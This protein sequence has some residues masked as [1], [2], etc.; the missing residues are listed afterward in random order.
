MFIKRFCKK[1][2]IKWH[3]QLVFAIEWNEPINTSMSA[4]IKYYAVGHRIVY[5]CDVIL[6]SWYRPTSERACTRNYVF[7]PLSV[8]YLN[9]WSNGPFTHKCISSSVNCKTTVNIHWRAFTWAFFSGHVIK[10]TIQ[11]IF[12]NSTKSSIIYCQGPIYQHLF[13]VRACINNY[14]CSYVQG[15]ITHPCS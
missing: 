4:L 8:H 11:G 10:Y 15:V 13:G 12:Y 3:V 2:I 1:R 6:Y 14:A 9:I 7:M 5:T